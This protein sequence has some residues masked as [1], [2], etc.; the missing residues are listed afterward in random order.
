MLSNPCPRCLLFAP[1]V[2]LDELGPRLN[3][4][5]IDGVIFDLEDSIHRDAKAQARKSLH[6]YLSTADLEPDCYIRVNRVGGEFWDD[7]FALVEQLRPAALLVP[8]LSSRAEAEQLC[9]RVD[10]YEESTGCKLALMP[11]IETI[12]GYRNAHEIL[13]C[14]GRRATLLVFGFEDLSAEL[15]IDR[16]NLA[17]LNPLTHILMELMVIAKEFDLPV[18]D[19]VSR[20]FQNA[21]LDGLREEVE[22]GKSWGCYGKVAVHPRQIDIINQVYELSL[23]R[24]ITVEI[25]EKFDALDDGS[26]VI[27]NQRGQMEG[28]PSYTRAKKLLGTILSRYGT[29]Q[30]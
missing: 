24:Q 21:D 1:A 17:T 11:T 19:S 12:A 22:L 4:W 15:G 9:A 14:I 6:E 7:D 29:R 18:I 26:F 25:V 27:V 20:K 13:G 28:T 8:K 2:K 16:P 30:R 23:V 10:A 3:Q 5:D